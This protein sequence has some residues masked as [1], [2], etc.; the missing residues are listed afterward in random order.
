M[1][2]TIA[3][4]ALPR[5]RH[6]FVYGALLA[7][8]FAAVFVMGSKQSE[9]GWLLANDQSI[10]PV[11]APVVSKPS[12]AEVLTATS[13]A[14]FV[15]PETLTTARGPLM[16]SPAKG[17]PAPRLAT[18]LHGMCSSM[19]WSCEAVRAALPEGFMLAC[20]TGNRPC[21]DGPDWGGDGRE[22]AEHI[23]AAVDEA[24]TQRGFDA[25]VVANDG[26]LMGF[27]R[28]AFVARD[29]AYESPGRYRAL[30]LIGA[31]LSPDAKRLRAS[32]IE[33]VVLAAGDYDMAK[34]TMQG[35]TSKLTASGIPTRFV[36]LGR[37]PHTLPEDTAAR[38]ASAIAWA[39][40]GE[41]S[42]PKLAVIPRRDVR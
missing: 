12:S 1:D 31:V 24:L 29:V 27:S 3:S 42:I 25:S 15:E 34:E 13:A 41:R 19:E 14:P 2:R 6:G 18:M 26:V 36:S 16:L 30:V 7:L 9:P 5:E 37:V 22:K 39:A 21:E 10:V 20:P 38:L 4:R 28:G 35:A 8:T 40:T 33:R 11:D 32:G 17:S 23:H